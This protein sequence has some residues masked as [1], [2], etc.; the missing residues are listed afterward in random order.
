MKTYLPIAS[1]SAAKFTLPR[2]NFTLP[3]F[4]TSAVVVVVHYSIIIFVNLLFYRS[5]FCFYDYVRA[6]V[7]PVTGRQC[8]TSYFIF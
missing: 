2:D 7:C 1:D 5:Y 8:M 3:F 6:A 4:L